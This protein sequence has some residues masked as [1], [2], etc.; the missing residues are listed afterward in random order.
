MNS[1]NRADEKRKDDTGSRS[2]EGLEKESQM[3]S[4]TRVGGEH[5]SARSSVIPTRGP[6]TC[7]SRAHVYVKR[8]RLKAQ[9]IC[10]HGFK[11][12]APPS[13]LLGRGKQTPASARDRKRKRERGRARAGERGSRAEHGR[14]K[15]RK[16]HCER[17]EKEEKGRKD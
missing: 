3:F 6:C 8:A 16:L 9:C 1:M 13:L 4:T 5:A 11:N 2:T 14:P 17:E 10:V 12:C 7:S 15:G